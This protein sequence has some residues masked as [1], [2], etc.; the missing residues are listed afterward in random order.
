MIQIVH[1]GSGSL[2]FTFAGPGSRGQKGTGSRIRIRNTAFQIIN[3][4][5]VN[6]LLSK[7]NV[8]NSKLVAYLDYI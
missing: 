7:P 1:P 3:S 5:I 8:R 6:S 4:Y 2:L